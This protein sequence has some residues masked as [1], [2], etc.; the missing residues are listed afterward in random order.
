VQAFWLDYNGRRYSLRQGE[1]TIGRSPYSSIVV[2]STLASRHHAALRVRG[3]ELEV[4]DLGSRNG[5]LVNGLPNARPVRLNAGDRIGI[6]DDELVVV[7]QLETRGSK[8][9]TL[10]GRRNTVSDEFLRAPLDDPTLP[11]GAPVIAV[12]RDD[13]GRGSAPTIPEETRELPV[14]PERKERR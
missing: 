9:Q 4:S 14:H 12:I 7:A 2:E 5:T 6:G 8:K 3:D 10:D 1:S 13:R 11:Q